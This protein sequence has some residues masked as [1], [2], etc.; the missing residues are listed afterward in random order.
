MNPHSIP[1]ADLRHRVLVTRE[2]VKFADADPYGHLA[3]GA[4]V[5]MIMSHRVEAL[6]DHVGFSILDAAGS[7]I[8][9]PTRNIDVSFLR[10]AFVGDTLE[11]AS[12]LEEL[13]T[14][15]LQVRAIVLGAEDRKA[16][17]LAR[18][19]FVTVDART[20]RTVAAPVELPTSRAPNQPV[21]LPRLSEYLNSVTGLPDGWLGLTTSQ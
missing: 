1:F 14:S 17:V 11:V 15:S 19:H 13:G 5:D 8:A 7:G 18:I 4:Y 20:G 2:R 10:P 16:R 21:E 6:Q 9:Y 3:S 12:W